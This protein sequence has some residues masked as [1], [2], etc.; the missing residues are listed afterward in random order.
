LFAL[1]TQV[2]QIDLRGHSKRE[3]LAG[4]SARCVEARCSHAARR[5]VAAAQKVV[6]QQRFTAVRSDSAGVTHLALHFASA[7]RLVFSLR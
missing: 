5:L 1:N 6:F 3:A 2:T 4:T 7:G